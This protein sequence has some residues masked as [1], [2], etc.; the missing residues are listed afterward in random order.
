MGE[1]KRDRGEFG[2]NIA[3]LGELGIRRSTLTNVETPFEP[4][5]ETSLDIMNKE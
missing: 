2:E 4:I 1:Y 3:H 5:V